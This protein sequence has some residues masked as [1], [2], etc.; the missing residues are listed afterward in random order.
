MKKALHMISI[1]L[2]LIIGPDYNSGIQVHNYW[3][4]GGSSAKAAENIIQL[5]DNDKTDFDPHIDNGHIAWVGYVVGG[6]TSGGVPEI[7]HFDG[8]SIKQLT[9]NDDQHK[10]IG[11]IQNGQIVWFSGT[12][13]S[14]QIGDILFYDGDLIKQLNGSTS[15]NRDPQLDNGQVVW[16]G[17][18]GTDYEIFYYDGTNTE[19]LTDNDY[20]DL[21]PNLDSGNVLWIDNNPATIRSNINYYNG[22]TIIQLVLNMTVHSG[23]EGITKISN[24]SVAWAGSNYPNTFPQ[25]VY[26]LD[27]ESGNIS[28]LTEQ[29][30]LYSQLTA[31]F[32]DIGSGQV[33]WINSFRGS[34]GPDNY[35]YNRDIFFF[36]GE[37]TIRVTNDDKKYANIKIDNGQIVWVGEHQVYFFNGEETIQITNNDENLFLYAYSNLGPR[38]DNGTIVWSQSDGNDT[39]I[40]YTQ[41]SNSTGNGGITPGDNNDGNANSGDNSDGNANSIDGGG[42]G[43][44][45]FIRSIN[46]NSAR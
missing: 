16:S 42:G 33:A 26:L 44:G 25:Q 12:S 40:Y 2:L 18:D 45:C 7:F 24:Q 41:A 1:T 4:F 6:F 22:T 8:V 5:T 29:Y 13:W 9:D 19:Q 11:N 43:G 23:G 30:S 39:E 21:F 38:I 17:F 14:N 10:K 31:S 27:I 20:D 35:D 34:V 28:Q 15:D 37:T 36:D 32:I 46:P 3:F